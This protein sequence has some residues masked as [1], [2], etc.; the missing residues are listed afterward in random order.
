MNSW[1]DEEVHSFVKTYVAGKKLADFIIRDK[2]LRH[3]MYRDGI[4]VH[5]LID[6]VN[7]YEGD[8]GKVIECLTNGPYSNIPDKI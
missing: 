2:Q 6:L 7:Y 3:P 5:Q 4:K 8:E 1:S